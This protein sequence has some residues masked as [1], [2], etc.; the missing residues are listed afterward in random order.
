MSQVDLTIIVPTLNEEINIRRCLDSILRAAGG[1][2]SKVILVDSGSSDRTI[3][4]ARE[5]P[6]RIL[7]L[8]NHWPKSCGAGVYTG[9]LQANNVS[10][11]IQYVEA[12]TEIDKLWFERAIA[13]LE[14]NP[15]V[16]AVAGQWEHDG[17]SGGVIDE[18]QSDLKELTRPTRHIARGPVGPFLFRA[19]VLRDNNYNPHL[20]GGVDMDL[21]I[22]LQA[23]GY[24]MVRIP[25]MM[26]V[27]H[28]HPLSSLEH[29]RK[30]FKRYG[31][32]MGQGI[33]Y[34]LRDHRYLMVYIKTQWREL[35]NLSWLLAILAGL[36]LWGLLGTPIILGITLLMGVVVFIWSVIKYK[37]L[38][39]GFFIRARALLWSLGFILGVL[40]QPRDIAS[41]PDDPIE[42]Q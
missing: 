30:V 41:F 25:Q 33:R 9:I 3:E 29:L 38:K 24:T 19:G 39:V 21:A 5:F 15:D 17:Q 1:I 23:K 16:A 12:D 20:T 40:R 2:E 11:Y 37:S 26:L 34:A 27:H 7:Q 22:R 4:L 10:R 28:D 14:N 13:Y 32:G 35:L 42:L 6:V 36:V 8:R 18:F 31:H